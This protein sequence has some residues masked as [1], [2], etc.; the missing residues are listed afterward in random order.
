MCQSSAGTIRELLSRLSNF[1]N[2]TN[3][4]EWTKKICQVLT[5]FDRLRAENFSR[6]SC[7]HWLNVWPLNE[8]LTACNFLTENIQ[9]KNQTN[10]CNSY[11]LDCDPYQ[12]VDIELNSFCDEERNDQ[13]NQSQSWD[14]WALM[15]IYKHMASL[16]I[17]FQPVCVLFV[18]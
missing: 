10:D 18:I 14:L 5:D 8:I 4:F 16:R 6:F 11:Q 2:A 3:F 13:I 17:N 9:T 15:V 12:L 1:V 7:R